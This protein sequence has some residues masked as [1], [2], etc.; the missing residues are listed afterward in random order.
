MEKISKK[1]VFF[2]TD[3]F[4]L[5]TLEA[6]IKADYDICA[7]VTK[8]DSKS[9]RGQ[10]LTQSD[11]KKLAIKHNIKVWQPSKIAEIKDDI[12]AL[13]PNIVGVLS[14]FG[15]IIPGSIIKLFNPGIINIHP[16][17]LP[18]YR[19]PTPIESAIENGDAET[20]IS[21]MELTASMDAGPIYDQITYN[22]TGYET[23]PELYDTLANIGANLLIKVLPDILDG[24]IHP[25]PQDNSQ[26]SYCHILNKQDS[27]VDLSNIT[28]FAAE[29][30]VRAHLTYPRTRIKILDKIVII[31]KAHISDEEM[32]PIDI[33]CVD[34]KYLSI[35]E[36]VAPSG[37]TMSAKD[38]V[39]GYKHD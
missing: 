20:G 2:G 34:N 29:R 39:N 11:V 37:K 32:S 7:V 27:L 6:L 3:S 24:L 38:F 10:K 16:S 30:L 5:A 4:S 33:L 26:S 31:T 8:P 28:S 13:G 14:S 35:D 18:K 1:I 19:G 12:Q 9:G 23:Q 21:I 22:L 25:W 17:L 15:K 36:L